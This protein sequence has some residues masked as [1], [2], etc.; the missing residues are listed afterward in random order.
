MKIGVIGAG[1]VGTSLG[2]Y[3]G[4]SGLSLTGFFDFHENV[5]KEAAEF[6]N[7]RFYEDVEL[8]VKESDVL[9]LT[10][11][12]GVITTV[13]EQIKDMPVSGKYVCHCSG[14]MSAR[15]AFP[16]AKEK[17]A[18]AY[19]VHPL[20]AVSDRFHSYG[21]LN[22]AYFTIE[23]DERKDAIP[24]LFEDLGN[25]VCKI[26][27]ADKATYHLAAAIASN[28]VVALMN[29]SIE[30]LMKCGFTEEGAR[31]ALSPIVKGNVSHILEDGTIASLTGPVE[32]ADL[33]TII[34][35]LDCLDEEDQLLYCLLSRKLLSIGKKKN[36]ERDY[37]ALDTFLSGKVR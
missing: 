25:P 18:Y 23:G 5:A 2:K 14:A 35:H 7:S 37:S 24:K 31:A 32:R 26:T 12:D 10:V 13:W 1:K 20:F 19:S 29:Q 33:S 22:G 28:H 36:P 15:D 8:L 34:K 17:G 27:A 9:F 11:P 21:E 16:D 4:S 30:L 3:L 6:T